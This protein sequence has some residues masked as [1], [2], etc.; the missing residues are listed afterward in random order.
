ML[1]SRVYNWIKYKTLPPSV[2]F[3]NRLYVERDSK[4]RRV[5]S[6]LGLTFRNSKW[7]SYARVNINLGSQSTYFSFLG[8][9]LIGF[10]FIIFICKFSVYY[11]S[12]TLFNP[13]YTLLWFLLDADLYLKSFLMSSL[14]CNL[15]LL[16]NYFYRT[17]LFNVNE[18]AKEVL[19]TSSASVPKRLHK[20][21]LYLW[22]SKGSH[23]PN[24]SDYFM[25]SSSRLVSD[26]Q[27]TLRSLYR[28]T[29][30]M[31]CLKVQNLNLAK[32]ITTLTDQ[33]ISFVSAYNTITKPRY[34]TLFFDYALS[35]STRSTL[36]NVET[37]LSLWSLRKVNNEL[38]NHNVNLD[39]YQGLFY[40][41][42]LSS[43]KLNTLVL[44]YPEL[45]TLK[46]SVDTQVAVIRWQ[47]WLYKYNILH[48]ASAKSAS[49]LTLAKKLISSGF[50]SSESGA[51]NIWVS[52]N[53]TL[54]SPNS[55]PIS[56][57]YRSFYGSSNLTKQLV[58][59]N[60]FTLAS[61]NSYEESYNWFLKRFY[62]F[63]TLANNNVA[64]LPELLTKEVTDRQ[65]ALNLWG[66]ASVSLT[67]STSQSLLRQW[68][69]STFNQTFNKGTQSAL[70]DTANLHLAYHD[71]TLFN[72]TR[73]SSLMDLTQNT[74]TTS[75][76]FYSLKSIQNSVYPKS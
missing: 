43:T 15:Q 32:S 17:T 42:T 67:T 40:Q 2:L 22:S 36:S 68:P 6:N 44:N 34:S 60:H 21:L 20:P 14:L 57:L 18:Q 39:S 38:S 24:L 74:S 11:N 73:L 35:N 66:K 47:R 12:S 37:E 71:S 46:E 54:N 51:R 31:E 5:T 59:A 41:P 48:R 45:S 58:G 7:S 64:V 62:L 19:P 30:L 1:F 50:Y 10:I 25:G 26:S 28:L 27:I 8:R 23:T 9:F 63:N 53:S 69:T 29:F 49:N 76:Q 56:S 33:N 4:H 3:L 72:S 61:L 16:L 75:V 52:G 70:Q 65:R 55:E 13:F